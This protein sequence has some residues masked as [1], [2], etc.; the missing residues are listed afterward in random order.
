MLV[1]VSQWSMEIGN[2]HNSTS[3]FPSDC[4]F[5][6]S[7]S[8]MVIGYILYAVLFKD[9][10]NSNDLSNTKRGGVCIYFKESLP[11]RLYNVSY[12]MNASA[13]KL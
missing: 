8:L 11:L 1:N 7:K 9:M 10:V 3:N 5:Y 4:I 6:L 12:S 13:L 2:F